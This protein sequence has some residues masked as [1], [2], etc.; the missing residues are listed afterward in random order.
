MGVAA[1]VRGKEKLAL[2]TM[3]TMTTML[4][5]LVSIASRIGLWPFQICSIG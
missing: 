3:M 1:Q 5:T 2:S 4:L